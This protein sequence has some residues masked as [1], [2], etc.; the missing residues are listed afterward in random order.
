MR[1]GYD[2]R[3]DPESWKWVSPSVRIDNEADSRWQRIFF[4]LNVNRP[5]PRT[6]ALEGP[7][8]DEEGD[9]GG[10][11]EK[12]WEEQQQELVAQEKRPALDQACVMTIGG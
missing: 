6:T 5:G 9:E 2:P 12:K 8:S 3:T 7:D 1:F 11:D 4:Y 10:K